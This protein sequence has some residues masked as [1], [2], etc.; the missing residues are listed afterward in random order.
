[1][2]VLYYGKGLFF[3]NYN[4]C[5]PVDGLIITLGC[6]RPDRIKLNSEGLIVVNGKI[7]AVI[8]QYDRHPALVEHLQHVYQP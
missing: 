3:Q 7:P 8:H 4:S 1:M 6:V 5:S 2:I